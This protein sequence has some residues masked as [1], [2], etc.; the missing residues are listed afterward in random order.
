M[1]EDAQLKLLA[2]NAVL[3]VIVYGDIVLTGFKE[4]EWSEGL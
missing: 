3:P 2:A 1:F 4:S